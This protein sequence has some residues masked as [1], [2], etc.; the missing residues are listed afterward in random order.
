MQIYVV[1]RN[2][3]VDL[4]AERFGVSVETLTYVNQISYPYRL[5]VGQALLITDGG[6]QQQKQAIEVNG[7]AYPFIERRVLEE[8]LLYLTDL[9]VFSYGFTV[10]G[11]LIPPETDDNWMIQEAVDYGTRP[12]L[13]LTPLGEDGRFDNNLVTVLVQNQDVQ[14]KLIWNLVGTLREKNF[15]GVDI[16]FEYVHSQDRE[17][18]AAFVNLARQVLNPFGYLV[19]VALAP[20]TSRDQK[21]LLYEGID[22]RLLGE[23]AN[24]VL[25]MTYE[26]GYTYGQICLW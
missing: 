16:D 23:A 26:W 14:Q 17:G 25:L 7:Y 22:Y 10:E 11:N 4:I 13:T 12:F 5:A 3:T 6:R 24:Q 8:T 18:F 15:R 21:G 2:D 20:K 9:S 1:A 19:F